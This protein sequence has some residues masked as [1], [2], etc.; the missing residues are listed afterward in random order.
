MPVRLLSEASGGVVQ[1]AL[2]SS[3]QSYMPYSTGQLCLLSLLHQLATATFHTAVTTLTGLHA[4]T[5]ALAMASMLTATCNGAWQQ[6][7]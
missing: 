3:S 2:V 1:A 4:F 5:T 6:K 7:G